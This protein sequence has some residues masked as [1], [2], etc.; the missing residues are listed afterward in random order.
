MLNV[1]SSPGYTR[2]SSPAANVLRKAISNTSIVISSGSASSS[3][4]PNVPSPSILSSSAVFTSPP[5]SFPCA[6]SG[7]ESISVGLSPK[8]SLALTIS[9]PLMI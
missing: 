2:P 1:M 7:V 5:V 3:S 4:S 9:A 8:S 6:V